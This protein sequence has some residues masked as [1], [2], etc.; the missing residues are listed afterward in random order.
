[1]T[2]HDFVVPDLVE[3]I[4]GH[5]SWTVRVHPSG[6]PRLCSPYRRSIWEPGR[7][8]TARCGIGDWSSPLALRP[9]SHAPRG[10]DAPAEGCTC[11]VHAWVSEGKMLLDTADTRGL[12]AVSGGVALWGEVLRHDKGWRASHAYPHTLHVH[13]ATTDDLCFVF[14]WET[15]QLRATPA[16]E[17]AA[18]LEET[19]GVPTRIHSG[20]NLL[21]PRPRY[22]PSALKLPRAH[23]GLS[24]ED[25][26]RLEPTATRRTR[27]ARWLT[28][29]P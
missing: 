19:Y 20:D 11:G 24:A 27:L 6:E 5:R 2:D 4:I 21:A 10:H 22:A 25:A 16:E 15:G 7:P 13:A 26:A 12:R 28:E 9:V 8:E 18:M 29:M 14:S 23:L 17:L 1:M 3:P